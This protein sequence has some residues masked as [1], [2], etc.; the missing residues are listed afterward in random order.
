MYQ[1]A[2]TGSDSSQADLAR[3]YLE[4][5]TSANSFSLTTEPFS[6]CIRIARC[7]LEEISDDLPGLRYWC[8]GWSKILQ[9]MRTSHDD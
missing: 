5:P 3:K 2:A 4:L 9:W 6:C 1:I 7:S 8:S